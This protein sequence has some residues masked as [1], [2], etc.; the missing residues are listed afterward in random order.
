VDLVLTDP[1]Y[2]VELQY[3]SYQDSQ[4]AWRSIMKW[5]IP[6]AKTVGQMVI[7]PSCRIQELSWIY[8]NIPPDWLMCWYK[9]SPGT[10]GW[11]G[12][13][14]F[15]PMLVYGKVKGLQMHDYFYAQPEPFTNGHP[16]PK[17]L[18]W[19]TWILSRIEGSVLDCFLGSGTVLRAAKDLG[20][21]AIGIELEERYCEIAAR[22]LQ[23]EVLAL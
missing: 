1:P 23:Q 18:K 20:R 10:S 3:A 7:T 8:A 5:F 9:G 19:A 16:C 2:G 17:P 12:F 21:K 13:N 4:D 14:D 15:E 22:R 6:I 11:L